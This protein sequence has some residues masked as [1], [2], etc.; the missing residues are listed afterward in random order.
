MREMESTSNE[1]P[2]H[3]IDAWVEGRNITLRL[4]NARQIV[5]PADDFP[6]LASASAAQLAQI[7]L[8][9]NGTA[10]RWEEIDE[11]ISLRGIVTRY[12]KRT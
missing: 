6:L 7:T 9:L 11:D 5:F 1:S 8:R 12:G 3:A 10:L 4:S 2:L